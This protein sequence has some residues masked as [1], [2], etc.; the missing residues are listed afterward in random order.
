MH[1][2][3]LR[4]RAFVGSGG[5]SAFGRTQRLWRISLCAAAGVLWWACAR[6]DADHF[7]DAAA[8]C[9]AFG[10]D[11]LSRFVCSALGAAY[12]WNRFWQRRCALV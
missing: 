5:Q 2:A 10:R 8:A 11:R 9:A 7:D 1:F 4:Y 3:S 6:G 12:F